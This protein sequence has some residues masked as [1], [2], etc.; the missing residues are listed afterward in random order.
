MKDIV[1]ALI[2]VV[3]KMFYIGILLMIINYIFSVMFTTLFKDTW[4]EYTSYDYFSTLEQSAFALFQVMTL[5]SWAKMC[6]EVQ[7]LHSWAWVPFLIYVI[8]SAFVVVNLVIAV[9]CD[10]I[11]ELHVQE[12]KEKKEEK[13][14]EKDEE[15]GIPDLIR[16]VKDMEQT[17]LMLEQSQELTKNMLMEMTNQLKVTE[18]L[19][20]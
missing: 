6:R 4:P 13:T 11:S 3:P 16:Q 20:R 10:A 9:V 2:G 8:I 5:D 12:E 15:P 18:Y 19:E 14:N 17:I 1:T 7:M